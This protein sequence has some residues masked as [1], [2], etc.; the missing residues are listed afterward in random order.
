M[1]NDTLRISVALRLGAEICYPH[2]CKC[3]TE[4]DRHGY[5][6]LLCKKSAGLHPRHHSLNET[7]RKALVS[8]GV[9]AILEP[10]GLAREDGK[11]PDGLTLIPW[12]RG[13]SLIWDA[14]C[15]HTLA[16]SYLDKTSK[17][18]GSAAQLAEEKKVNHY[19]NLM[20]RYIF[21][22]LGFESLGSWGPS[23]KQF[24]SEVGKKIADLTKENR[25][26]SYLKQRLSIDIQRGNAASILGTVPPSCP[27]DEVY[28]LL[29]TRNK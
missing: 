25:S 2:T 28:Y 5:H 24:V 16:N 8:A 19:R 18:A 14:T 26:T 9:P 1:D 27:L 3:G 11:Q 4:A 13:K 21:V 15:R 10:P 6:G 17:K 29:A 7:C 22:P 23:T 20:D 12:S